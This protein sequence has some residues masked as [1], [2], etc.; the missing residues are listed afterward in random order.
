MTPNALLTHF[1]LALCI[2]REARGES[3]RGKALV[4]QVIRNRVEDARWPNTYA[5]VIT[6]RWQFSAF[7]ANDP[8]ALLFP[9]EDE[10]A[11]ADCVEAAQAVLEAPQT[12]TAANHYKTE[13]VGAS[14]AD[15]R[16]IVAREGHH[17][18]YAL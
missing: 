17:V 18:F 4:G 12:S 16:K 14:W 5:G 10:P 9:S 8:N 1:M 6:Q 13:T 2:Y 11:W 15:E 7:N 3:M